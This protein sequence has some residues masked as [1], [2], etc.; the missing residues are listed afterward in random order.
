ME[1]AKQYSK[2]GL[3]DFICQYYPDHRARDISV[4][5]GLP[6]SK[7]YRI[8]HKMGIKKSPEFYNELLRIEAEK[9]IRVGA[10]T[11]FKPGQ[12][13][14][15]KGQRMSPEVYEKAKDT[16][17]KK[18]QKPHNTKPIGTEVITKDGYIKVKIAN[19]SS[20]ELKHRL[21]WKEAYG[22]IPKGFNIQFMDRN[23]LNTNLDNLYLI[24]RSQQIDQ[25][26]IV[27]Y[28]ADIRRAIHG[29]SKLKKTIKQYETD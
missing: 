22:E 10:K 3:C 26:S 18:G 27:R 21:V 5:T 20:W 29:V 12:V 14:P 4:D 16:M 17:F 15:N 19:P 24:S 23:R 7:I 11:R 13:S 2:M 6:I 1:L 28:P 9:L 25:N 8:A